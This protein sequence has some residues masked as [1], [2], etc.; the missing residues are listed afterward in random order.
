MIHC[1]LGVQAKYLLVTFVLQVEKARIKLHSQVGLFF[2]KYALEGL[3]QVC[4]SIRNRFSFIAEEEV[5]R[6]G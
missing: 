5:V 4:F 1:A 6:L 2:V 3:F